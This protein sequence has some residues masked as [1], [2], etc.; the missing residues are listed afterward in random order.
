M[1]SFCEKKPRRKTCEFRFYTPIH[2]REG[3]KLPS[4]FL[5]TGNFFSISTENPKVVDLT[6][7]RVSSFDLRQ[8]KAIWRGSCRRRSES[9]LNLCT[10]ARVVRGWFFPPTPTR[11]MWILYA[12]IR[13]ERL[14]RVLVLFGAIL[15]RMYVSKQREGRHR[16]THI[17]VPPVKPMARMCAML[18]MIQKYSHKICYFQS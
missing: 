16:L 3:T 17:K 7:V 9:Y 14:L 8:P 10:S 11:P 1:S 4:E 5:L 12:R 18:R 2:N 6:F 13:G 15:P